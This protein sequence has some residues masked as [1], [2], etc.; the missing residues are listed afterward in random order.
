[1]NN[2][3]RAQ[4]LLTP[5]AIVSHFKRDMVRSDDP[6]QYLYRIVGTATHSETR[7]QLVVYEA[8]YGS[9]G[10]YCRPLDMFLSPVD[11]DKY[12]QAKQLYRFEFFLPSLE[13]LCAEG[14]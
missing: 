3:A 9:K 1:M 14:L 2:S 5:G 7:E 10:L 12:P 6:R 8:L 13:R 4:Q 11:R